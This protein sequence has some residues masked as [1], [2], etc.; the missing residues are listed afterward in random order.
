MSKSWKTHFD[1]M[2]LLLS[3]ACACLP[4]FEQFIGQQMIRF[5]NSILKCLH[6]HNFSSILFDKIFEAHCAWILSRA[7]LRVNAW[8]T[9]W[10]VFPAFRL[11]SL[12]FFHNAPYI[13][14]ITPS[15]NF[16][17]PSVCVHTSHQ[18]YG[19]SFFTLHSW[20]WTHKSSCCSL[21]YF[22]YHH[23]RWW[24]PHGMKTTTCVSFN[25]VQLL[26][27]M[28]QHCVHQ[29]WHSHLNWRCHC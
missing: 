8:L 9:T 1:V 10:L 21:W 25:H 17:Y 16:K 29:R 4:L 27:L 15:L 24:L 12:V 7:G 23:A 6:H 19:Y 28:G 14:W 26:L 20:Q 2:D 5:Q 3:P 11:S 22:C 13:T 18:P